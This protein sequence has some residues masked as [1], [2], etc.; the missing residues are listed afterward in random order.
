M[1][2]PE[3]ETTLPARITPPARGKVGVVVVRVLAKAEAV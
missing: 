2:F 1:P 3:P